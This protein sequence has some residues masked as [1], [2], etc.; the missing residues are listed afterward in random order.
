MDGWAVCRQGG[1]CYRWSRMAD[2]PHFRRVRRQ[3]MS[4]QVRYRRDEE[5][6]TMEHTGTTSD[7]GLGGAFVEAERPPPTG[8]K[9]LLIVKMATAWDPLELHGEVRWVVENQPGQ[10]TGFGIRFHQLSGPQATA[11]Y[12]LVHASAYPESDG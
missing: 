1:Q 11:L 10:A 5:G 12:E 8:A 6:A 4:I 2:P 7:L 3:P 9:V